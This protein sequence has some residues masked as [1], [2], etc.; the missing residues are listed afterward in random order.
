MID[1]Q[2]LSIVYMQ[3]CIEGMKKYDDK[4]FDLAIVDP[5]YGINRSTIA[6]K[7][8]GTQHGNAAAAKR[9]YAI[10]DWDK[11]PP[12]H[13]YFKGLFRI[14]K[15]QII[16]GANHFISRMPYDASCWIV[17]DKDNGDND[18]ADCEL[19]WTS[20]DKAAR[21]FKWTWSGMLQHDMKNK[22]RR[23][24]PTQKPVALY[25]WLLHNYA[26]SGDLILDTHLGSGSS[27]IAAYK[28]GFDFVGFEID[29]DYYAAQE[30]RF[31]TFIAQ[32]GYQLGNF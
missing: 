19:A 31:Q 9:H 32:Q 13:E 4:T 26:K 29:A 15:N 8:S 24:H 14:S 25:E 27:R 30:K 5:P 28:N 20:F 16:W 17:W 22:E 7:Q 3:D 18:F 6:G 23:I 1:T 2:L 21:K 10:K 11:Q 12:P